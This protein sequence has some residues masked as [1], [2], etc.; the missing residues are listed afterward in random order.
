MENHKYI[1]AYFEGNLSLEE[2]IIFEKLLAEDQDFAASFNLEKNVKKAITLY[3]RALLKQKLQ[4]FENQK[5]TRKSL[6]K[7]YLVAS[8]A[9]LFGFGFWF[10]SKETSSEI[11]YDQYYSTYPNV[12]MPTVR[13][14]NSYDKK[15]TAFYEYDNGNYDKAFTLFSKIY[16]TDKED[17][18]LFYR[19]LCLLELN[20]PQEALSLF[21]M[22]DLMFMQ[23]H[24]YYRQFD[25][26]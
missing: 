20:K 18:V 14:T 16:V 5:N 21:E 25:S 1:E 26:I 8:F 13:G 22:F 3:E 9:L 11:L 15:A 24:E 6:K 2:K 10:V 12:V 23:V 4:S 7:W 17:Y 19:A